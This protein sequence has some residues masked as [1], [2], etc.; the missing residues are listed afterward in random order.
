MWWRI[1][2]MM[3]K[4]FKKMFMY[5]LSIGILGIVLSRI[6]GVTIKN[7]TLI[8]SILLGLFSILFFFDTIKS[9]K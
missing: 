7:S 1:T 8:L 5:I 6:C 4:K 9:K 3:M 2:L